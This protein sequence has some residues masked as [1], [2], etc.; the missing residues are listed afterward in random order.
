MFMPL[1]M[2]TL[3]P[4]LKG[5]WSLLVVLSPSSETLLEPFRSVFLN[6]IFP[7]GNPVASM[8]MLNEWIGMLNALI[9]TYRS[10]EMSGEI[11]SM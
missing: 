5:T 6:S 10:I 7:T 8:E 2:F 4:L 11:L 3:V 1:L 9:K